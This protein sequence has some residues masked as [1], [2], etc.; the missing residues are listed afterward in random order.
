MH[1]RG[2]AA[3]GLADEGIE[4]RPC[5]V[6]DGEE[7][8]GV[9]ALEFHT[10]RLEKGDR[11]VHREACEHL[12][13]R[14]WRAADEVGVGHPPVCD[15]A[16]AATGHENL[17]TEFAGTIHGHD[18]RRQAAAPGRA[19]CPG[20]REESGCP[21]AHDRDVDPTGGRSGGGVSGRGDRM[22][23]SGLHWTVF[24]CHADGDGMSGPGDEVQQQ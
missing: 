23:K 15:V 10:R 5:R 1:E 17:G 13:D 20:R 4:H 8:A 11:V 19:S 9:F 2:A 16:A 12:A 18:R 14:R 3:G 21:G 22:G 7:L 6:G 24:E